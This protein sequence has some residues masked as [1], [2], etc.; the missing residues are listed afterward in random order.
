MRRTHDDRAHQ[1]GGDQ[2]GHRE[3]P[4]CRAPPGALCDEAREWRADDGGERRAAEHDGDGPGE[5]AV[6]DEVGGMGVGRRPEQSD[7]ERPDESTGDGDRIGGRECGHRHRDREHDEAP[8]D[9]GAPVEVLREAHEREAADD[10]DGRQTETSRPVWASLTPSP[11]LISGSTAVGAI[12]AVTM[13]NVAAPSTRSDGQRRRAVG[14]AAVS[15][16]GFEV[17][18]SSILRR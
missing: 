1:H 11:A 5:I 4:E 6:G 14:R 7:R 12:S 8:G 18:M 17:V 3:A 13:T 10:H 2:G 9:D 15:T 16:T